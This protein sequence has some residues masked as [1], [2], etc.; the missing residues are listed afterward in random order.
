MEDACWDLTWKAGFNFRQD[1]EKKW[2]IGEMDTITE[3]AYEKNL[4]LR[5]YLTDVG[6]DL[7]DLDD[8]TLFLRRFGQVYENYVICGNYP[9]GLY[10]YYESWEDDYI[11]MRYEYEHA[12]YYGTYH[13]YKICLFRKV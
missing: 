1:K 3:Y 2:I 13:P 6:F 8:D 4:T 12:L 11:K 7:S 5:D 10:G 9:N